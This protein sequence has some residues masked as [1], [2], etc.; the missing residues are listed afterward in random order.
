MVV[1]IIRILCIMF[2]FSL[3]TACRK[4]D[5]VIHT[6]QGDT[7]ISS[8]YAGEEPLAYLIN[9]PFLTSSDTTFTIKKQ[10]KVQI[11]ATGE[12]DIHLA[13]MPSEYLF[14][15]DDIELFFRKK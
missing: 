3:F 2:M 10:S 12:M 13:E 15:S 1:T 5:S 6:L 14:K 9:I 4:K 8:K 7:F 11:Y